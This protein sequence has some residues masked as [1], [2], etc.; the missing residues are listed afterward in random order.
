MA[1]KIDRAAERIEDFV[2]HSMWKMGT[3]GLVWGV[4]DRDKM[5]HVSAKGFSDVSG[6][7][8]MSVDSV[9][10]I[11][12]VSKSFTCMALL[13][14]EERGLLRL[15]DSVTEH[16]PWFS[17]SSKF[18]P[19]TL[20]HLM[21]HTAGIVIGSDATPST[22]PEVWDLRFTEATSEPG[23]FFHYS[24][25]GYK[26]L[27]LVIEAVTGKGYGDVV[28]EGVL[29]AA[30]MGATEAVITNSVR[31]RTA[32]AHV[33]TYDDR[34][35]RRGM[36]LSP[37]PWFESDTADGSICAPLEDMLAYIRVLI[38]EGQGQR[39]R[40]LSAESHRRM[41]TPY[42][43]PDDGLH[44][45][46]YGYG[47]NIESEDGHTY[48]GHQGGMVGH[49]TSMLMDVDLGVGVMVMVNGPGDPEEVSRF[50]MRVL[51]AS[52]AGD[53][54][55]RVP[56]LEEACRVAEARDH[57]GHYAAPEGEFEVIER[58]GALYLVT[59][60]SDHLLEPTE[61]R[62][63]LT[64][65]PGFELFLLEFER[66][67]SRVVRAHHGA[68]TYEKDGPRPQP[69]EGTEARPV[70]YEGHFRSHNPW[71][72]SFR[73]VRRPGGLA[74]ILP[75]KVS[76]PMTPIG[77][78]KFRVGRDA[79]SP[80]TIEFVGVVDEVVNLAV[81]SGADRFGRTFTE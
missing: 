81:V 47:L 30:G 23:S 42:I 79:R 78:H 9:F 6:G 15:D 51:R 48:L 65:A 5:L 41:T 35:F 49:Y 80:E 45:G 59:G 63:F 4:T 67:G 34:P 43:A 76:E 57:V 69:R 18:A 60:G 21:T 29:Q 17:V 40:V 2:E 31:N 74:M 54:L 77:K 73:V 24:N 32:V 61:G 70:K 52:A 27:G 3:P 8:P 36:P 22:W 53:D 39:G 58:E 44:A 71:M 62:A 64:D 75:G 28:S 10:Q 56:S 19:I 7:K 33:P 12:S 66:D 26:I 46:M 20:H 11:G 37:A 72:N 16:L 14:L 25:T 55:P 1:D 38:N 13:Q 50:A 68:R